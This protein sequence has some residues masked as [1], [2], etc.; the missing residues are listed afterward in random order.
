MYFFFFFLYIFRSVFFFHDGNAKLFIAI[1]D[2]FFLFLANVPYFQ[3]G[4][5]GSNSYIRLEPMILRRDEFAAVFEIL[6]ELDTG[7]IMYSESK[8][9]FISLAMRAGK[10]ELR[11]T[12]YSSWVN[13]RCVR[14]YEFAFIGTG[15]F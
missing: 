8:A 1:S 13:T 3:G 2:N 10:L 6:P 4:E 15:V 14:M 11:Y 7:L 12:D 9:D 5:M